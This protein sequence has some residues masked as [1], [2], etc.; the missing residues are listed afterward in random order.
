MLLYLI[1][2][3]HIC[4]ALIK[5]NLANWLTSRTWAQIFMWLYRTI[6]SNHTAGNCYIHTYIHTTH[7]FYYY[8]CCCC[9]T[10]SS[11]DD[12]NDNNINPSCFGERQILC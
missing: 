1:S 6:V 9:C 8:Y 11:S 3:M 10:S 5:C 7:T 12:D 4:N 2:I